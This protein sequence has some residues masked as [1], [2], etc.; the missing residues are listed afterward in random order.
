MTPRSAIAHYR[1]VFRLGEGGMGEIWHATNTHLK[2]DT[3]ARGSAKLTPAA[4]NGL[5]A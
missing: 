5:S 2:C 3:A 4:P 1:I